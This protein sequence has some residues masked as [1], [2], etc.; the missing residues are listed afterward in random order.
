MREGL[1]GYH[2]QIDHI[3]AVSSRCMEQNTSC[4]VLLCSLPLFSPSLLFLSSPSTSGLGPDV[5]LLGHGLASRRTGRDEEQFG[6]SRWRGGAR[7]QRVGS[8]VLFTR[9]SYGR[10]I[11]P[12]RSEGSGE[13]ERKSVGGR[14]GGE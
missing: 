6:Q 13:K 10:G 1:A 12:G 9:S 3:R 11:P 4:F 2:K 5:R 14:G 7:S 8:T